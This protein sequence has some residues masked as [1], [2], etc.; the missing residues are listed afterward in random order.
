MP[1]RADAA[2]L[3]VQ[4]RLRRIVYQSLAQAPAGRSVKDLLR[5]LDMPETDLRLS[6][7]RLDDAGLARRIK[8]TWTAVPLESAYPRTPSAPEPPVSQLAR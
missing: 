8:G 1:P 7:R 2:T 3:N 4:P 5:D 6:L